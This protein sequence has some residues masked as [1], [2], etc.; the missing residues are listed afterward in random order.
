MA[1]LEFIDEPVA[2]DARLKE[3]HASHYLDVL[4]RRRWIV[5]GA[6]LLAFVVATLATVLQ[7]ASYRASAILHVEHDAPAPIEVG[8]AADRESNDP[9]FISTEMRLME[10]RAVAERAVA[11]L[12]PPVKG[13]TVTDEALA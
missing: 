3:F 8:G 4:A 7:H 11:K 5:G 10:N 9:Q 12:G 6:L 13:R 1:H 2:A